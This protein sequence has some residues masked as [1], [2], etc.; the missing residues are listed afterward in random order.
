M[1]LEGGSGDRGVG[2]GKV[3]LRAG[4][5]CLWICG[6][7]GSRVCRSVFGRVGSAMFV[8]R[9]NVSGWLSAAGKN[10]KLSIIT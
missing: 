7:F 5:V 6:F 3:A 9:L 4:L 8:L 2:C 1:R 10:R